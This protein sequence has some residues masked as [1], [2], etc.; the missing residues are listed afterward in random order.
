MNC[1]T[2]V[3]TLMTGASMLAFATFYFY[4]RNIVSEMKQKLTNLN[5]ALTSLQSERSDLINKSNDMYVETATKSVMMENYKEELESM[6]N[7]VIRLQN[8]NQLLIEAYQ[9]LEKRN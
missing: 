8:D 6:R 3:F 5:T 9:Q 1:T 2:A 4:N 7:T